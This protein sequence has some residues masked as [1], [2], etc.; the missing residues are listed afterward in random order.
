MIRV[1]RCVVKS[2]C[3]KCPSFWGDFLVEGVKDS[4]CVLDLDLAPKMTLTLWCFDVMI[5]SGYEHMAKFME[6]S[7]VRTSLLDVM[8]GYKIETTTSTSSTSTSMSTSTSTSTSIL[9]KMLGGKAS[10][11]PS[12]KRT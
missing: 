3:P 2:Y 11:R 10:A 6:V 1:G 4:I 5:I 7:V 8:D 9:G 12:L